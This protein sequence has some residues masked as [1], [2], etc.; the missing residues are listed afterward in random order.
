MLA[1][2]NQIKK[3]TIKKEYQVI[4]I[5]DYLKNIWMVRKYFIDKYGVDP[6]VINGDQMPLNYNESASQKMLSEEL[7]RSL[8]KRKL[9]AFKRKSYL[10]HTTL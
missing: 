6:P 2:A 5:K 10:L 8:C 7:R 4:G 1:L 9:H 3:C